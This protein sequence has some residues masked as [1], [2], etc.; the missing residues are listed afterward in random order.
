MGL[1]GDGSDD[2]SLFCPPETSLCYK[3]E[4]NM[5]KLT[6]ILMIVWAALAVASFVGSFFVPLIPKIIGIVFGAYNFIIMGVWAASLIQGRREYRKQ[7]K[8]LKEQ[9]EK[10]G[11]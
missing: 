11:A 7:M 4:K 3:K 2:P 6:K 1:H 8:L 5:D 10:E 9:N